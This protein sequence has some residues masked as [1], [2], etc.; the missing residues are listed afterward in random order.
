MGH[1]DNHILVVLAGAK[2]ASVCIVQVRYSFG[3]TVQHKQMGEEDG[4]SSLSMCAS[5]CVHECVCLCVLMSCACASI[6]HRPHHSHTQIFRQW[7]V[8][9][10]QYMKCGEHHHLTEQSDLT[11]LLHLSQS[12]QH[13]LKYCWVPLRGG[14]KRV[15]L[16]RCV[17]THVNRTQFYV[18]L[19]FVV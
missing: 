6:H 15:G 17:C 8:F 5:V 16:E 10:R 9:T 1:W 14:D 18:C 7:C 12:L 13:L 3:I 2:S 11:G 19:A 4:F